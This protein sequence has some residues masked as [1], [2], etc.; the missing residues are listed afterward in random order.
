MVSPVRLRDAEDDRPAA[1]LETMR[2]PSPMTVLR[3][4]LA[5]ALRRSGSAPVGML[6]D[7]MASDDPQEQADLIE[8]IFRASPDLR[9]IET[10]ARDVGLRANPGAGMH[11]VELRADLPAGVA[12]TVLHAGNP[13]HRVNQALATALDRVFRTGEA[14]V[15]VW[16]RI[17]RAAVLVLH[18]RAP[19][20]LRE[21]LDL[22]RQGEYSDRVEHL[23][24]LVD[25]ATRRRKGSIREVPEPPPDCLETVGGED[26][27]ASER[28]ALDYLRWAG[29]IDVADDVEG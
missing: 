6:G 19:E 12:F 14:D 10:A 13:I 23:E 26:P 15:G 4:G 2:L 24:T 17:A 8:A 3:G 16:R 28:A 25:W 9:W 22:L 27:S 7:L 11:P 20:T 1:E 18:R 29:F 5:R 21:D